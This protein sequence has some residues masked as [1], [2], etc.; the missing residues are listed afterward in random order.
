MFE[1]QNLGKYFALKAEILDSMIKASKFEQLLI[2]PENK[3]YFQLV[4]FIKNFEMD[5]A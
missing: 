5:F 3:L 4:D 2:K 1:S